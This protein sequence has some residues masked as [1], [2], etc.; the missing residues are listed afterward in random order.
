MI[1]AVFKDF[2][3]NSPYL[4]NA[5]HFLLV[6]LSVF[7]L[8][9]LAVLFHENACGGGVPDAWTIPTPLVC[10]DNAYC[11]TLSVSLLVAKLATRSYSYSE[12]LRVDS[13]TLYVQ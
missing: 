9:L 8:L 1:S 10:S 7:D 12:V 6:N 2:E 5:T 13:S 3:I 11:F 4:G